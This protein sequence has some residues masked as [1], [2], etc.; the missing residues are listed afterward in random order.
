MTFIYNLNGNRHAHKYF[1]LNVYTQE[2]ILSDPANA[3]FA[4]TK[5]FEDAKYY[6]KNAHGT[7]VDLAAVFPSFYGTSLEDAA[8]LYFLKQQ[9]IPEALI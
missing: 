5:G 6:L 1:S 2:E 8:A 9:Y 7:F 3:C 4:P